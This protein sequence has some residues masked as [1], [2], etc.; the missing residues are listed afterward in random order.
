MVERVYSCNKRDICAWGWEVG[1]VD[2]YIYCFIKGNFDMMFLLH[3]P[4]P[5]Q[6]AAMH[7]YI[8]MIIK[9]APSSYLASCMHLSMWNHATMVV[10]VIK[11]FSCDH[12]DSI[13]NAPSSPY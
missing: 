11:E 4:L 7:L 10:N 2:M 13:R 1:P 8:F 9:G 5:C 6:A 12:I 3:L